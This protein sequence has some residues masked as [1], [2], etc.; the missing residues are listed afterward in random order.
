MLDPYQDTQAVKA[1]DEV[2]HATKVRHLISR[3]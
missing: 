1:L 3:G 2:I